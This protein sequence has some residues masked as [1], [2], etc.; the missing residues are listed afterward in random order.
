MSSSP[1]NGA[2]EPPQ[3]TVSQSTIS[4]NAAGGH[5]GG[6]FAGGD[7][8]LIAATIAGN[9]AGGLGGGAYRGL[10][11]QIAAVDTLMAKNLP[12]SCAA[13]EPGQ[14][15]SVNSLVD[16]FSCGLDPDDNQQGVDPK[17]G[18]LGN[19]GGQTDTRAL[20]PS[21]PAVDAGES[22]ACDDSE[23]QRGVLRPQGDGCDIGAYEASFAPLERRGRIAGHPVDVYADGLGRVGLRFNYDPVGAFAPR[24]QP[25]GNAGLAIRQAGVYYPAGG[26]SEQ[27]VA[28]SGPTPFSSQ[29]N[30]RGL[31]SVY[32][33]GDD[34]LV[35]ERLQYLDGAKRVGLTYEIQNVS[36]QTVAFRAGQLA[37]L[38][39]G[40]TGE[41]A[42]SALNARAANGATVRLI[43]TTPSHGSQMGSFDAA[44]DVFDAFQSSSGLQ[45]L[46]PE[47]ADDNQMGVQWNYEVGP[48]TTAILQMAWEIGDPTLAVTVNTTQDTVP[49]GACTP[50]PGGCTLREAIES[51]PAGAVILVPAGQ[52]H[53]LRGQLF[54][55]R[56][57]II[58]G[59]GARETIITAGPDSRV[60]ELNGAMLGL[61][62]VSLNGGHAPSSQQVTGIGGGILARGG[63]LAIT[64]SALTG[65]VAGQGGGLYAA[66]GLI[67]V[68]RTAIAGNQ[69]VRPV[70]GTGQ[71]GGGGGVYNAL[72][73]LS[74]VNSTISGNSAATLGGGIASVGF[75]DLAHSTL[76]GNVAVAA[77]GLHL[78]PVSFPNPEGPPIE[79]DRAFAH[80]HATIVADN[81]GDTQC[82]PAV[83]PESSRHSLAGD[84]SCHFTG[85]GDRERVDPRLGPLDYHGGQT[86][87]NALNAGSPALNAM[88]TALC[89]TTDQRS[90]ARPYGDH[91]D[92]G[93]FEDGASSADPPDP[94]VVSSPTEGQRVNT[95]GPVVSGT[96]EPGSTVDV[97]ADGVLRGSA[98]ASATGAFAVQTSGLSDGDNILDVTARNANGT[99]A[100][101]SRAIVV[102]TVPPP[103][104]TLEAPVVEG[105]TVTLSGVAN[106]ATTV[107]VIEGFDTIKTVGV[108]ASEAYVVVLTNVASGQHTYQV[109]SRDAAGNRSGLSIT[110]T[111]EVDTTAPQVQITAGP[112]GPTANGSPI[113]TFTANESGVE[114]RCRL[115]GHEEGVC[116]SPQELLNLDDGPYTFVVAA[117]DADGNRGEASRTFRIDRVAPAAPAVAGG[118]PVLPSTFALAGQAEPG[119]EVTIYEGD[120]ALRST[121]AGADG[122]WAV[123]LTGVTPGEHA[124]VVRARD[125]AGNVSERSAPRTVRVTAPVQQTPVP[126]P[127]PTTTPEPPLPPPVVAEQVNVV[128]K[129]GKV[130]IK[131]PGSNRFLELKAGDQIPVGTT[132]DTTKGRVTLTSAADAS[133]TTRPRTSTTASS[134]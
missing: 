8:T 116:A 110:H 43:P 45:D 81:Q 87:T 61:T 76:A 65:N 17:L 58:R 68:T 111:I 92:I 12:A 44:D 121:T 82:S 89:P 70:G 133:G 19:N 37:T 52:Y 120:I 7:T 78:I 73:Q 102:D 10:G 123:E 56:D 26:D 67:S 57:R 79:S 3:L 27:R 54:V 48:G 97:H 96:A 72:A 94:P 23:D 130:L 90:E 46:P 64:D 88:A 77:A 128:P 91:C 86:V 34:L 118:E 1:T 31:E 2:V 101:T 6:I 50:A 18:S 132:I 103:V 134:A 14:P 39:Q 108:P 100:R 5:G 114:F 117:L 24:G 51:A 106:D 30:A 25:L 63:A 13:A 125:A 38:A 53:L 71:D 21:S 33:V 83:V 99:S 93:A 80:I 75:L 85:E 59:A 32:Y 119:S 113:F 40:A 107:D 127:V 98:V 55:D 112:A 9:R 95:G 28:V 126:T 131:E 15:S 74:I 29:A 66:T 16:D 47:G 35:T 41:R 124:Y 104:P 109:R 129:A 36:S 105:S 122:A 22:F 84:A 115:E 20:P 4:D 11:A 60:L 42:G 69:A 49:D 62:G